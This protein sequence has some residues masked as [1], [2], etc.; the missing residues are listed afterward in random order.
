MTTKELSG[1]PGFTP[2]GGSFSEAA[3]FVRVLVKQGRM[4]REEG[5]ILTEQAYRDTMFAQ[6]QGLD[7]GLPDEL[8]EH[9]KKFSGATNTDGAVKFSKS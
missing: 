7:V 3:A 8:P 2:K 1:R 9:S 6:M 5:L 4:S